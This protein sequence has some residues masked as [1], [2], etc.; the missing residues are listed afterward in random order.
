MTEKQNSPIIGTY[1]AITPEE[2]M[3]D[4]FSLPESQSN[5]LFRLRIG[6]FLKGSA[7]TEDDIEGIYPSYSEERKKAL[8]KVL[9]KFFS[10]KDGKYF[11]ER[12]ERNL[13]EQEEFNELINARIEKEVA[14]KLARARAGLASA[15]RRKANNFY[16]ENLFAETDDEQIFNKPVTNEQQTLNKTSTNTQQNVNKMP[17]NGQQNV[18]KPVTNVQQNANKTSTNAQQSVNKTSTNE[19]QNNI[20]DSNS[21]GANNSGDTHFLE[22]TESFDGSASRTYARADPIPIGSVCINNK[23]NNKIGI[24]SAS[25]QEQQIKKLFE[26]EQQAW[27]IKEVLQTLTFFGLD[28]KN[29][30][31][32]R[33][34]NQDNATIILELA[35][36]GMSQFDYETFAGVFSR[37]QQRKVQ[38]G[39]PLSSAIAFVIKSLQREILTIQNRKNGRQTSKESTQSV[40]KRYADRDYMAGVIETADGSYRMAPKDTSSKNPQRDFYDG[41]IQMSDGSYRLA[42]KNRSQK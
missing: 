12:I 33:H 25:D 13:K 15:E 23:N 28:E 6:Y 16:E 29:L 4:Y 22:K 8:Q 14:K 17:T 35:T 36:H 5:C 37:C 30:E 20:S 18:N 42:P 10:K 21:L 9:S 3:H 11:D 26:R 39:R 31:K 2:Y 34:R 38:E 32:W 27:Q 41:L 1:Y 40:P 19:Q 7:L 24:G